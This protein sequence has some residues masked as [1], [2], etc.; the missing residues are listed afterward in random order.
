MDCKKAI[1]PTIPKIAALILLVLIFG[2]PA[3][4]HRCGGLIPLNSPMPPCI[5]SFGIFPTVYLW[6]MSLPAT[7]VSTAIE[8][9]PLLVGAYLLALYL[10]VCL[11]FYLTNQ[12]WKRAFM[13]LVF[14]VGALI[15]ALLLSA[16]LGAR[17]FIQ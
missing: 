9:N 11:L 17:T 4:I 16:I 6:I 12:N 13:V 8:Y 10:G 14:I 3:T 7:D 5:D 15:I 1:T 2:V